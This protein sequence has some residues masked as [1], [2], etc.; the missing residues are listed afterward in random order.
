[1]LEQLTAIIYSAIVIAKV[2][3]GAVRT[4]LLLIV[5]AELVFNVF[6]GVTA[7]QHVLDLVPIHLFLI[8]RRQYEFV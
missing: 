4:K 8:N 2:K 7:S 1:M 3:V 5:N 6:L